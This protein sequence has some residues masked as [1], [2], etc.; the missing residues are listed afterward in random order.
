MGK[1]DYIPETNEYEIYSS[2]SDLYL[3]NERINVS[4]KYK[5]EKEGK[6]SLTILFKKA[7]KN[8]SGMFNECY[9]LTL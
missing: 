8:M 6:Y 5:F 2:I 7:I 1:T 4:S 9:S 3:N